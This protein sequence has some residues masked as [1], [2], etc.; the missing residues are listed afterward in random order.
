LLF[1][2]QTPLA[3]LFGLS[4]AHVECCRVLELGCGN[5]ANLIPMALTL[6]GSRFT[7]VD[8]AG[9][10]IAAARTLTDEL[11]LGNIAFHQRDSMELEPGFAEFD[12][13]IA[14]GVYS[15]VPPPV[16]DKLLAVCR[17]PRLWQVC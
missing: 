3:V 5:G 12:Y 16:R 4:P 6:P 15:W 11:G 1:S 7:G 9:T 13:I 8:L 10:P 14:H 2:F 17:I